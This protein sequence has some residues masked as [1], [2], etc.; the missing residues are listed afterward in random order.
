MEDSRS[1]CLDDP[2]LQAAYQQKI[3]DYEHTP[4]DFPRWKVQEKIAHAD[5]V[6]EKIENE[7][8]RTTKGE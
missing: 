2:V 6:F 5:T 4:E 3:D 1:Q 8:E 7:L